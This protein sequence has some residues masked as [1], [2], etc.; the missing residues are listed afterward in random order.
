IL[1]HEDSRITIYVPIVIPV[2]VRRPFKTL[3]QE[4]FN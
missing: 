2:I 1:K 3:P 4:L